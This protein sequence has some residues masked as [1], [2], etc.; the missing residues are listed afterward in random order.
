MKSNILNKINSDPKMKKYLNDNSYW[1]KE[2]NRTPKNFEKFQ[3]SYKD[4]KKQ[5]RQN[6]VSEVVETL[7]TVN[8]IFNIIK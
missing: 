8:T 3:K 1:Y 4:N 7:D 2:L 6:K 5:E